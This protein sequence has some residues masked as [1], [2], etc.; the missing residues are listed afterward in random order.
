[1]LDNG[2]FSVQ[3]GSVTAFPSSLWTGQALYLGV[4]VGN[5]PEMTPREQITSV[6]YALMCAQADHAT[7]SDQLGGMPA[8]SYALGSQLT[9]GTVTSVGS[10]AGLTG[11]PITT[12]GT[13]SVVFGGTTGSANSAARSDHVHSLV[14]Y[15][16]AG[17]AT[18]PAGGTG[19][20]NQGCAAGEQFI[21]GSCDINT[22]TGIFVSRFEF[23]DANS[24]TSGPIVQIHCVFGS[25]GGTGSGTGYG[26]ALC[27]TLGKP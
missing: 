14:V 19:T 13:L 16:R 11:G 2:A 17:S 4:T 22:N 25:T 6:P 23:W 3:L 24:T 7:S 1:M 10:G 12:S 20:V 26:N 15:N 27:L 5:D 21:G 18:V 8:A 9:G